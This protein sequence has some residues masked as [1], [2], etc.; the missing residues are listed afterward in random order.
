MQRWDEAVDCLQ[1]SLR[2]QPDN[3]ATH[4]NLARVFQDLGRYPDTLA[5]YQQVLRLCP[6][7]AEARFWVD[8]LPDQGPPGQLPPEAVAAWYDEAAARWEEDWVQRFGWLSPDRMK[9]ALEPAPAGHSLDILDLGCGTG[10]CGALFRDWART[11]TGVD[12]SPKMLDRARKRGTYDELIEDDLVT[13]LHGAANRFDLILASDVLLLIGD[14]E[15]I[16]RAA[17]TALRLGGRFAFTT[18]RLAD[19]PGYRLLPYGEFAHS[20]EYLHDLA[21]KTH[22]RTIR[23]E[24]VVFPGEKQQ[25]A[26]D[27]V[28]VLH[29]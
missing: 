26:A 15:P 4:R 22:W 5:A 19:A 28:V 14:L 10:L 8:T 16:F 12:L 29:R 20:R 27:L 21:D 23:T 11:L 1:R 9:A 2:R 7:D 13:V 25:G 24:P 6:N 3:A 17:Q 18:Y